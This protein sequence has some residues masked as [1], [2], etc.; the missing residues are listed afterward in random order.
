MN[1]TDEARPARRRRSVVLLW[2]FAALVAASLIVGAGA[3]A[4]AIAAKV[5]A[6]NELGLGSLSVTIIEK[7]EPAAS[8]L[9]R[10]GMT[11][12]EE[13]LAIPPDAEVLLHS[14]PE[15]VEQVPP[16]GAVWLKIG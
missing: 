7:T 5:H 6:I 15:A 10:N 11:S 12:G 4:A 1:P 8:W 16:D 14:G 2:S 3:K 13:P 9:G